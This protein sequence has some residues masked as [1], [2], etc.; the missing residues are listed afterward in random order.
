[1]IVDNTPSA[2]RTALDRL[3]RDEALRVQLTE[4][5]HAYLRQH[6]ILAVC[7][8]EWRQAIQ[9]VMSGR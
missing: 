9:A 6:R 7:A 8:E 3:V 1:M 2:W 4:N 5:A